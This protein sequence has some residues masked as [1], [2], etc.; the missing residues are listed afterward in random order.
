[1]SQQVSQR[2]F[3]I[4]RELCTCDC[5]HCQPVSLWP[6][7][8]RKRK[9]HCGVIFPHRSDWKVLELLTSGKVHITVKHM[10]SSHCSTARARARRLPRSIRH[11]CRAQACHCTADVGSSLVLLRVENQHRGIQTGML[12]SEARHAV[13]HVDWNKST[14]RL[15]D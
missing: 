4:F 1:M 12:N 15:S 6:E 7:D 11:A 9:T 10:P 13:P 3:W 14:C 5:A 8:E 2:P